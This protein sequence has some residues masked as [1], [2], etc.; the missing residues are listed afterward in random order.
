MWKSSPSSIVE[1]LIKILSFSLSYATRVS[2]LI[3]FQDTAAHKKVLQMNKEHFSFESTVIR[4]LHHILN[5]HVLVY[6]EISYTFFFVFSR[7]VNE[8]CVAY[9]QEDFLFTILHGDSG[10]PEGHQKSIF[11]TPKV[12]KTKTHRGSIRQSLQAQVIET[13]NQPIEIKKNVK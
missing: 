7:T 2:T 12:K 11:N 6:H 8:K 4:V 13:P 5:K 9:P 3:G 10:T 1:Q